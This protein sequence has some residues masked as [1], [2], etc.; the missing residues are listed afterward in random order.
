MS[1]LSPEEQ[2]KQ[3]L[4]RDARTS[5][6]Y[7][8]IWQNVDKCVFCDLNDK[9]IFFEENGVVMTISLFAYID[10]H[11]MIIPRRHVK[12]TKELSQLEWDTVRKFT[13]IA[14]KLIRKVHGV[15]GMQLIQKDGSDGQS[16]VEHLHFH[17]V[18]YDSPDLSVW[19]Y[20]KLKYTPIENVEL[21]K[22]AGSSI[23]KSAIKYEEKYKNASSLPL[24]CDVIIIN[25]KNQILF[26]ERTQETK[27]Y[28]DYLTIPGGNLSNYNVSIE[29]ELARE[30]KEEIGIDLDR[31]KL[32]LIS[33]RIGDVKYHKFSKP[34]NIDFKMEHKFVWNTYLYKAVNSKTKFTF[35]DD[36][37]G[38]V[39]LD[40][41]NLKNNVRISNGILEVLKKA[42]LL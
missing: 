38:I 28:P 33:S 19:N 6:E 13:Y 26:Q 8:K 30:V 41:K 36:C 7:D 35:G 22:N 42:E 4:Y 18:P 20:R 24:I 34:L 10:G 1:K 31:S 14:R 39:W 27:L 37:A 2:K 40:N 23:I 21:Y 15:K 9:Y 12:S 29:D 11:F 25:E 32:S 5:N 3:I 16:T 17:C